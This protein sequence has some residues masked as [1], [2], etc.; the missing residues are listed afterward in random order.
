MTVRDVA[1]RAVERAK[2][3]LLQ[4][5]DEGG[6]AGSNHATESEFDDP[7]ATLRILPA[8]SLTDLMASRR[9]PLLNMRP[10]FTD[11]GGRVTLRGLPK[12]RF[13]AVVLADGLVTGRVQGNRRESRG[14][15]AAGGREGDGDRQGARARRSARSSGP[16]PCR[17]RSRSDR[18]TARG[19][20]CS[21]R[22]PK[23][24]TRWRSSPNGTTGMGV[25]LAQGEEPEG[26]VPEKPEGPA[27][28]VTLPLEL[29]DGQHVVLDFSKPK[30][31][32]LHGVITSAGKPAAN[33][34]IWLY[35]LDG[36]PRKV[37]ELRGRDDGTYG[38]EGLEPGR[39][40]VRVELGEALLRGEATVSGDDV[41]LDIAAPTGGC[42][43]VV[44]GA[45]G[46]PVSGA[47]VVL[48]VRF[49]GPNPLVE[50]GGEMGITR[51][52]AGRAKTDDQGRFRIEGV[53][54][55]T[56][57]LLVGTGQRIDRDHRR[58]R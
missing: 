4:A 37:T 24:R 54:A 30:G 28:A 38:F 47:E 17:C 33:T 11:A 16:A 55:G 6:L 7:K 52:L 5:G 53:P 51:A 10:A 31:A 45:D 29:R 44:Y 23:E 25:G 8:M 18:S 1:G 2:L 41:R 14:H 34:K 57:T 3:I 49:D 39:Y 26:A 21:R 22:S 48:G 20:S 35:R 40:E 36:L 9:E 19:A 32:R 43:G 12:G 15:H 13:D 50:L 46:R 58:D 42:Y 27:T 56:Y